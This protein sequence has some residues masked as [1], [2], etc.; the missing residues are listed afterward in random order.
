MEEVS[1]VSNFKKIRINKYTCFRLVD[2][3][4]PRRYID[5]PDLFF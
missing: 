1:A 3:L 4:I 5:L 2:V